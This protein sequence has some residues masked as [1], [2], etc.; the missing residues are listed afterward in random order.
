[1]SNNEIVKPLQAFAVPLT[2]LYP[3]P[4][5]ARRHPERN[6][7][8]IKSS[9]QRFGQ[10]Q[11]IIAAEDGRIIVGNG[12]YEA[13]RQLG[14]ETVAALKV[15]YEK[16]EALARAIADNRTGELAEWDY[17]TLSS[18]FQL[19]MDADV[20]LADFGWE[21]YEIEPLLAADWTPPPIDD[22]FSTKPTAKGHTVEFTEDDWP[23]VEQAV[24]K[25]R[26]EQQNDSLTVAEA[27]VHL[28]RQ[29]V[30]GKKCRR[31]R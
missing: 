5:N 19:L 8:A 27:L 10:D 20:E 9:L 24:E 13:A 23:V 31:K 25:A 6:L 17:E 7:E 11:L 4:A 2:D 1:M 30:E 29:S 26:Q 14:W 15:P 28:C 18:Q 22:S 3:D 21:P 12:R 16:T